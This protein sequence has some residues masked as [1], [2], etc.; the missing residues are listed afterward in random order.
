MHLMK[1]VDIVPAAG[2]N[3][4]ASRLFQSP[5][6]VESLHAISNSATFLI[7]RICSELNV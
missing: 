4:D 3:E 6:E 1:R 5:D 2:P 7:P